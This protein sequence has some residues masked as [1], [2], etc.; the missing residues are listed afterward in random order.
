MLTVTERPTRMFIGL[1]P[2]GRMNKTSL[3]RL[4]YT[5]IGLQVLGIDNSSRSIAQYSMIAECLS[6][7]R[8]VSALSAIGVHNYF[9]AENYENQ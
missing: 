8:E 5:Y 2:T 1:G 3:S 4:E 9:H 6:I 7:V